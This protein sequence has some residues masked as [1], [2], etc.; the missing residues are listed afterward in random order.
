MKDRKGVS[1]DGKVSYSVEKTGEKVAVIA[2]GDFFARGESLCA[3]I[4][5]ELGFKPTLVNPRFA[6]FTDRELLQ[7]LKKDHKLVVTLED[8]VADG[9]FGQK[10]ASF[11]GDSDMKVKNYGL[12]KKFYDRYDPEELLR[13]LG[14]DEDSMLKTIKDLLG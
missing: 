4:E 12:E 11:Y 8:G 10:I 2:L 1:F 5:K 3:R 6:S 9:G 13:S 14:M 7:S